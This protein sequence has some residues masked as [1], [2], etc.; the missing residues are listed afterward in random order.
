MFHACVE[1]FDMTE[2]L[3]NFLVF[4]WTKQAKQQCVALSARTATQRVDTETGRSLASLEDA[5]RSIEFARACHLSRYESETCGGA[6]LCTHPK[7]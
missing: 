3:E 5:M 1:I 6:K 4:G 7:A 2:N